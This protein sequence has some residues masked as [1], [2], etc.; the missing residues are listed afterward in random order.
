MKIETIEIENFRCFEKLTLHLEPDVTA[1][2]GVNGAGKTALLDAVA[3]S[4][5]PMFEDARRSQPG[6]AG[7]DRSAFQQDFAGATLRGG[8]FRKDSTDLDRAAPRATVL[9]VT[10]SDEQG[11]RDPSCELRWFEL[12]EPGHREMKLLAPDGLNIAPRGFAYPRPRGDETQYVPFP[13][14]AYYRDSRDAQFLALERG[15]EESAAQY[16][17]ARYRALNAAVD[18]SETQRWFYVQENKELRAARKQGDT[19]NTDPVL[20]SIRNAVRQMLTDIELL[21]SDEDPPRMIADLRTENERVVRLE[22]N[23]LSAGQRNLMALTIDFARRLT[24]AHGGWDEPLKA[25]GILIIDEIELN[26]HPKWQQAVISH[27]RKVFPNTQLVVATHSPVV[28]STLES[29]QIRVLRGQQIVPAAVQTY[30]T[31]NG[32]VQRLVMETETRPPDN[33]ITKLVD[34]LFSCIASDDLDGAEE[35]LAELESGRD[36]DDPTVIEARTM[37]ENRRW[38]K[39]MGL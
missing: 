39:D 23:Q 15:D 1:V 20:D 16:D 9:R 24:L 25:P 30:G 17:P 21:S 4:L 33:P 19:S 37:I 13:A 28:L 11:R 7:V 38:E 27:L 22:F 34:A 32:R 12:L 26:L 3:L 6:I 14:F 8:D 35:Q 18:F 10:A 31:D 5:L 29:R 36:L 2:I